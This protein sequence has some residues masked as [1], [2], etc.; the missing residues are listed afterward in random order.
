MTSNLLNWAA[1]IVYYQDEHSLS[2]LVQSL[3]EQNHKP[4]AVFIADNNSDKDVIL[5]KY[6]FPI[7]V[8]K[9]SDNKGFAA[10]ANAAIRQAIEK[11]FENIILL[12]QDVLLEKDSSEKMISELKLTHGLVFPTMKN[13]KVNKI[14]SKG[15]IINI[16]TGEVKLF[17]NK[18]PK[19]PDWADGS[20]L[21]FT[22]E[23]YKSVDGFYEKYFMYF[24]D[25]DFCIRA[26]SLGFQISHV[27]TTT[28]QIPRGPNSFFRSRNS[29]IL[30]R[31]SKSIIFMCSTSL[32]NILGSIKLLIMFKINES[33]N[34]LKGV[35][36]GWS[37]KID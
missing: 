15:G 29:I 1:C 19:S 31:R 6:V 20:C 2:N 36:Q 17:V 22:K 3:S 4:S 18:V 13:R 32:R 7:E 8:I 5:S 11:N 16:Y 21:A 23:L 14:F 26:K 30:A 37:E 35:I 10:G 9:L 33:A 34:R 28:S 24:E 25:V 27:E 12:S